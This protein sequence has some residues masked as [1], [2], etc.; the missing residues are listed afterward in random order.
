[1]SIKE[2]LRYLAQATSSVRKKTFAPALVILA[3]LMSNNVFADSTSDEHI[4]ATTGDVTWEVTIVEN[5]T[6]PP[7]SPTITEKHQEPAQIKIAEPQIAE[8]EHVEPQSNENAEVIWEVVSVDTNNSKPA[9][10]T[11]VVKNLEEIKPT[12]SITTD[13]IAVSYTHLTLPTIYSV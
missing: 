7:P 2:K 9:P 10:T 5:D 13:Y 4:E 3:G 1:M 6:T 11:T 12:T 8:T